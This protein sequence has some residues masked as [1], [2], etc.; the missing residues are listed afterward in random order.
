MNLVD[1]AS[2]IWKRWSV[3]ITAAQAVIAVM[4]I[5]LPPGWVPEVPEAVRWGIVV[6]LSA[7]AVT[8]QT[9]KQKNLNA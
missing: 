1:E 3:Q 7:A 8:A 6:L 5:A 9:V 4:W 2:T